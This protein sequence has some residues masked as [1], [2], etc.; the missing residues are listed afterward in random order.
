MNI[1]YPLHNLN[2]KELNEEKLDLIVNF[3]I[4]YIIDREY[5]T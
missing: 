4:K 5:D 2:D 1:K 3:N